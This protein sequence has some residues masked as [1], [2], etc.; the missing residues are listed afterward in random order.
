MSSS[1]AELAAKLDALSREIFDA[2]DQL[3]AQ[4]ARPDDEY[5]ATEAGVAYF[6]QHCRC[7]K[8]GRTERQASDGQLIIFCYNQKGWTTL[9]DIKKG[10]E[11]QIAWCT[12]C[13]KDTQEPQTSLVE[14]TRDEAEDILANLSVYLQKLV[15]DKHL[16]WAPGKTLA[17]QGSAS[18]TSCSSASNSTSDCSVL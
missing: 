3:K 8:S 14:N 18:L 9:A 16:E 2:V 4:V 5:R 6:E 11:R 7:D 17:A 13:L 10:F 15:L 1:A 12:Q